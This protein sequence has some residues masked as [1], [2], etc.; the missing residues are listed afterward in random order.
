MES[1]AGK[2]EVGRFKESILLF[3]RRQRIKLVI[4]G[5]VQFL[6]GVVDLLAVGI[7]AILGKLAVVG[8]QSGLATGKVSYLL[9]FLQIE[10]LAIQQQALALGTLALTLLLF[11]SLISIILIQ[12]SLKGISTASSEISSNL[13]SKVFNTNKIGNLG[14][15]P[16]AVL[17][18][19]T[20][21]VTFVTIGIVGTFVTIIGD[22]GLIV[23]MFIG[24]TVVDPLIAVLSLFLFGLSTLLLSKNLHRRA[25]RLGSDTATLN[26]QSDRLI[27][28]SISLHSDL[29]VR[30]RVRIFT[31]RISQV[32]N[33]LMETSRQLVFIP[34]ISKYVFETTLLLGAFMLAG[35]EF[36]LNDAPT[37]VASLTLFMASASR[38]IPALLRSQQG[39]M[40]IKVNLA[41]AGDTLNLVR[42][43]KSIVKVNDQET[44]IRFVYENFAPEIEMRGLEFSYPGNLNFEIEDINLVIKPGQFVA[45]VGKSGSGKSTLIDLILGIS[46]LRNGEIL[47]S[48]LNP[49]R[50]FSKW[51]GAIAYVPQNIKLIHGSLRENILLGYTSEEIPDSRI[52]EVLRSLD[53]N[54]LISKPEGLDFQIS[55]FSGGLSGGQ[56][57]RIGIARALISNPKVL[58]LDEATS[59]LDAET[60]GVVSNLLRSLHGNVTI[61][62]V[63][64]RLS[65]V[66][67]ADCLYWMD[68][69]RIVSSGTFDE[70]RMKN[71]DFETS[72]K[73]L[74]L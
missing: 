33:E 48:G 61:I 60:E 45:L 9:Q 38:V 64:H 14:L 27:L 58:V 30:N 18:A 22:L 32:R 17:Y 47:I 59:S 67:H 70:L 13:T 49:S 11:K 55:T 3:N 66:Q 46:D 37:A 19:L 51:P 24:I 4:L 23:L 2:I 7:L 57:Q 68:N 12:K 62:V 54:N 42:E 34:N 31:Q 15:T 53:L 52:H 28:E 69:G 41:S 29:F 63:A 21:G 25:I 16:Q 39:I 73:L 74:R 8:V 65:T 71:K 20:Q 10:H 50:A 5:A 35:V 26:V 6:L 44:R 40:N 72:V 43:M 56:I 1:R 36:Y